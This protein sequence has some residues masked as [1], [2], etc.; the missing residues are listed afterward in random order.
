M[1]SPGGTINTSGTGALMV[2]SNG[3]N[4][5]S[6]VTVNGLV[7]VS[8]NVNAR[9][10]INNGLT[11]NGTINIANGGVVSLDSTSVANQTIAAPARST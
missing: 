4:V 10:R 1:R 11:L 5:L 7:D 8:T 6:G 3:S 9:E 2:F